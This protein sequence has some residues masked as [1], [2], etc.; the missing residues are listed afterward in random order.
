MTTSALVFGCRA[1][2][3]PRYDDD[4]FMLELTPQQIA[5]LERLAARGFEIV[6]FPLYASAV[7]VRRGNCAALLQPIDGGTMR[8]FADPCYLVEGNL[9]VRVQ[10]RGRAWFVWKKKQLEATRER[11]AELDTFAQELS[12]L[13]LGPA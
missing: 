10:R 3:E 1:D 6:A 8:L 11:Q 9:S 7:G 2:P 12:E 4:A 5:A 13:L